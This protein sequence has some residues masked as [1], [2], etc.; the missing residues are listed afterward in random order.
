MC[1]K[2]VQNLEYEKPVVVSDDTLI[3]SEFFLTEDAYKIA[4]AED[5]V[6]RVKAFGYPCVV[7]FRE[8]F[9][10]N[11]KGSA[12][13]TLVVLGEGKKGEIVA[14]NKDSV[15][16]FEILRLRTVIAEY[17]EEF[18]ELGIRKVR[19]PVSAERPEGV[20]EPEKPSN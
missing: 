10:D 14:W 6:R 3:S 11:E 17:D 12:L 1:H 9:P 18:V 4:R 20:I 2:S 19:C 7:M 8:K 15:F 13:H 5:H 16:P